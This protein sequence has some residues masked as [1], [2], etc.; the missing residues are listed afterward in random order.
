[1]LLPIFLRPSDYL[2]LIELS[3]T[4]KTAQTLAGHLLVFVQGLVLTPI[5]IKVAGPETYGT[6]ILL[7]SYMSIMFGISS[8][9]VGFNAKRWLPSTS[10][11]AE[12]A[13]RFYPQFWFQML[14]VFSLAVLS[15]TVYM[16]FVATKQWQLPGFSVWMVPA[17]L[18]AYTLYSQGTDYFRYTHR[19]GVFNISTV[20]QPYLFVFLAVGFYWSANVL[21]I[22]SLVASLT[23]AC[24][25]VGGFL[26][27]R[28]YREIGLQLLLPTDIGREIKLGLPLVLSYLVD[29][30]LSGGDRYI[31]AAMLSLRDVGTY[32]PAYTLGS[33]VMVLPRVFGVVLPPLISQRIDAGDEVGAKRLSDGA[34]RI[35][36]LVSVPYVV[37]AAILGKE[38]LRL[39]A[40]NEVAEAAW[41]V[42][43]I[44]ALASIFYGLLQIKANILFVRLNTRLLF[45][46]NLVSV[47]LN[48]LL[49]VVL[50]KLFG[51]VIVAA[52]AALA[53]YL[54][55]YLLLRRRLMG[56]AVDFALDMPW[57][58]RVF[59]CS[60]GMALAL[61]FLTSVSAYHGLAAVGLG[62][63]V[64]G[65]TYAMLIFMQRSNRDELALLA[66]TM[67]AR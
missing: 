7:I 2:R 19:V 54:L 33:L 53:S 49:N 52:V 64:G 23:I 16:F 56:D 61:V 47:V 12:R 34:A 22:G 50:L 13:A 42:I 40:N 43:S 55:S 63:L 20:A 44:V 8:M 67:R 21:N 26:F 35:F 6:Y 11:A 3:A 17:Y 45:Q 24:S 66:Q 39:Y 14:S 4:R 15:A 18:L 31:I 9:G 32:V 57:L 29:V 25:A 38:V 5:V 10:G 60:V 46:I 58:T 30:S 41:P 1:V 65:S 28:L 51:N 59:I 36:L 48:I 27:L 37:G 62:V